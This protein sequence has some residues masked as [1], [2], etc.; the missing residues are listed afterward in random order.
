MLRGI[1][2]LLCSL[3]FIMLM[4]SVLG[5]VRLP[6]VLSDHMVLQQFTQINLWGWADPGE[7]ITVYT[8]WNGKSYSLRADKEGR[9]NIRLFSGGPGGPYTIRF[10]GNNM[11]EINDVMVGEVWVCSGQSNMEFTFQNLGGWKYFPDLKKRIDTSRLNKIRLCT[12]GKQALK[13]PSDSCLARWLPADSSSILNFSATAF[14]FGLEINKKFNVPVGLIVS[15]WG[16][17]PAEA[18]TPDEYLRYIPGLSFYLNHPNNPSWEAS[19]PSGLFNGMIYPLRHYTIKGVI[20]YQGESNR[21]DPDL[22]GSLFKS[23]ILSWRRYWEKLDLPFYFVQ[24]APFNYG[25]YDEASGYLR[26]AQEKALEMENTGMAVTLD[27][28]NLNDIHPKNKQEVGYRLSLLAF[29]QAYNQASLRSST[30]PELRFSRIEED[31]IQ[32]YLKNT[33]F[34]YGRGDKL[35]GFRI[36][37]DDGIF[38]PA[39]ALIAGSS[40]IVSSKEVPSPKYVR[41]AFRNTDTAS[42]FDKW[43]LPA[44]SFRTDSF[45]VNYREV[46]ISGKINPVNKNLK[47]GLYCPDRSAVIRYTNDGS[48][49]E[50]TSAVYHDSLILDTSC[51]LSAKAFINE[52]PSQATDSIRFTVHE[53]LGCKVV[54]KNKPSGSYRGNDFTL[55]DGILGNIGSQGRD[56]LGFQG[57]DF[58]ATVDLGVKKHIDQV[59]INFLVNTASWIFP[60]V[61]ASIYFSSDGINFEKADEF[62][63]EFPGPSSLKSKPRIV[64]ISTKKLRPLTRYIKIIAKNQG[65]TPPWHYAPGQKCW[66]FVDE[67]ECIK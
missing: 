22:Y 42:V 45:P 63:P 31:K 26:E 19:A 7:S 16:G 14:C 3:L 46:R 17:T 34:L 61:L 5:E 56:W 43:G 29:A 12:I 20:W 21:Y 27:I 38:K 23:M 59:K 57:D 41:Y 65:L 24:I 62:K 66:L 49:P 58:E 8:S 25:D 48:T 36:A 32:V 28:G 1:K 37:G 53:A 2:R 54:L 9:W 4:N 33:D 35:S 55:T 39:D 60:P 52:I 10:S 13:Q 18:W 47:V 40:V 64:S 51:R 15:S 6:A 11:L 67:V 44:S 50:M 30:S